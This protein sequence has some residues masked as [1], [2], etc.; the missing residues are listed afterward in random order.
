MPL[1]VC[2]ACL[3]ATLVSTSVVYAQAA[4]V[5]KIALPGEDG[6]YINVSITHTESPTDF[7]GQLRSPSVYYFIK[8]NY[9]ENFYSINVPVLTYEAMSME[10]KVS[11]IKVITGLY[12]DAFARAAIMMTRK[13]RGYKFNVTF[14]WTKWAQVYNKE[15]YSNEKVSSIFPNCLPYDG[16]PEVLTEEE[17]VLLLHE[18]GHGLVGISFG[19]ITDVRMRSIEEG[20]V[21]HIAGLGPAEYGRRIYV[22]PAEAKSLRGLAQMDIDSSVWGKDKALMPAGM[23]GGYSG[24]THHLHG[25][26][27]VGAYLE[28]FGKDDFR[29]FLIRVAASSGKGEEDLGTERVR[30]ILKKMGHSDGEISRFEKRLHERIKKNVLIEQ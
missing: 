25:R 9:K 20:V 17:K 2:A 7:E 14:G 22:T 4:P 10:Q 26:E 12:E 8:L 15:I 11:L 18:I 27:F 1:W 29:Q 5:E 6:R 28:I 24:V 13:P 30:S 23:R 16:G 19:G 21:D 3:I